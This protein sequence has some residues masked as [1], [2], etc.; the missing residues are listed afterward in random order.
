M[1]L[2]DIKEAPFYEQTN[3]DPENFFEVVERLTNKI[4]DERLSKETFMEQLLIES[5]IE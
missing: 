4:F 5:S 3:E 2:Q 1:S